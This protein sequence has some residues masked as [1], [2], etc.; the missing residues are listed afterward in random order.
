MRLGTEQLGWSLA[1]LNWLR[2]N[3]KVLPRDGSIRPEVY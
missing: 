1:V 3:A 2:Q